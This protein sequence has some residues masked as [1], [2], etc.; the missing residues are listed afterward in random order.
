MLFVISFNNCV[1]NPFQLRFKQFLKLGIISW[2][3]LTRF[4]WSVVLNK[5]TV[6]RN[7]SQF[8][9]LHQVTEKSEQLLTFTLIN[10]VH[11]HLWNLSNNKI[12]SSN[13]RVDPGI[14]TL[15]FLFQLVLKWIM[16]CQILSTIK[17]NSFIIICIN[18]IWSY[19]RM[20]LVDLCRLKK[21]LIRKIIC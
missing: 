5:D 20:H 2:G 21:E 8:I 7:L 6:C 14:I 17:A 9:N 16:H 1:P 12:I 3:F 18:L 11:F 4:F 15:C 13:I 10:R 19:L